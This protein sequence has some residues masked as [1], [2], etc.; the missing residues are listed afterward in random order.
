M[1][2]MHCAIESV[3]L[4]SSSGLQP[5]SRKALH[6][7]WHVCQFSSQAC[8]RPFVR[9]FNCWVYH[10]SLK[11]MC[12]L[13]GPLLFW[14]FQWCIAKCQNSFACKLWNE[15]ARALQMSGIMRYS[16]ARQDL[17][18]LVYAYRL[19]QIKWTWRLA[20]ALECLRSSGHKGSL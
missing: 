15:N 6:A 13:K 1:R 11:A 19:V 10:C 8:F 9:C 14:S 18:N 12:H 3:T 17:C 5:F 7:I 20:G 2:K 16:M 4:N